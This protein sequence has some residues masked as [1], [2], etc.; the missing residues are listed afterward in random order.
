MQIQAGNKHQQQHPQLGQ[1]ADR[2][3]QMLVGKEG[4][5]QKIKERRSDDDPND[6]FPQHRRLSQLQTEIAA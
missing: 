2:L 4:P 5:V 3:A 6:E 1:V